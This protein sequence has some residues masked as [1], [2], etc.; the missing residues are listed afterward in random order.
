VEL[1]KQRPKQENLAMTTRRLL[2]TCVLVVLATAARAG[3]LDVYILTGQSNAMGTTAGE[4]PFAPG[5]HPADAQTALFWSNVS[6]TGSSDPNNIVLYGDSG[7]DITTLLM[8]QGQGVSPAFWGTEFG[9]ARALYDAGHSDV[10]IIKVPRG[11]GGNQYWLPTT[12]HMYNHMVEQVDAALTAAQLAGNTFDVKGLV[13]L[14]G[15]SNGATEAS[16]ADV[17][18]RSLIDGLQSHIN[19]TFPGIATAMKTV[20]GEIAASQSN[21]NRHLTTELQKSLAAS[22]ADITFVP[23]GDLPLKSDFLHFGRDEKLE[24]GRRFANAFLG[25]PLFSPDP[26][27]ARYSAD[28]HS[29]E[30]IDRPTTQK[31]T[32]LGGGAG[33]TLEGVVDAG[34]PAWRL[35]DGSSSSNPGYRHPLTGEDAQ[36]MR[37]SG[38]KLSVEAKVVSGGGLAMWTLDANNDPGWGIGSGT[39]NG[40]L[41]N[42]VNT[43]QLEVT[44]YPTQQAFNLGAGSAD[45]FHTIELIAQAGSSTF[46]FLIDGQLRTTGALSTNFMVSG[47]ENMASFLSGDTGGTGREVLW[48]R[49]DLRAVPEPPTLVLL[50]LGAICLLLHGLGTGPFFGGKT[51]FARKS[52]AENTNSPLSPAARPRAPMAVGGRRSGL[53]AGDGDDRTARG[54]HDAQLTRVI[55]MEAEQHPL[56]TRRQRGMIMER[57]HV[58][59]R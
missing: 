51:C 31:W 40:V 6:A 25:L 44:V 4:T 55:P 57:R 49:F 3:T 42:R 46:D 7:G 54:G 15:E 45:A 59:V 14:Q 13:Y 56:P 23:T 11:G 9:L 21:G 22:D 47:Y 30:T 26:W 8:Q 50:T 32:E 41:L 20:I 1:R 38:W 48:N 52:S 16:L 37:D 33:V 19:A 34:T 2:A 58:A 5:S 17:R 53:D 43:D 28:L 27:I 35:S 24:I 39:M 10:M 18:L 12:G 29:P 36:Q